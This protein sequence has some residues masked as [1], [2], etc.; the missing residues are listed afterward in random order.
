MQA[1]RRHADWPIALYL[2]SVAL[3]QN[4]HGG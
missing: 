4:E 1:Q 3:D 2:Q